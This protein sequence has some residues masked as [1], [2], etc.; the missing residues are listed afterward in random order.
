MCK[1]CL[2]SSWHKN[3]LSEKQADLQL[4]IVQTAV[5]DIWLNVAESCIIE[6]KCIT[7]LVL[8]SVADAL[9]PSVNKSRNPPVKH[10]KQLNVGARTL[11]INVILQ[12]GTS[13]MGKK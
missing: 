6:R 2:F 12:M 5:P 8:P 4:F 7:H 13:T 9:P 3:S 10:R 11:I 1:S